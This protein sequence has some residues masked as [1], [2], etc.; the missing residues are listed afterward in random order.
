MKSTL[1]FLFLLCVTL[2]L[3]QPPNDECGGAIPLPLGTPSACPNSTPVTNTFNVT[4]VNATPTTPYPTFSNCSIGNQTSAPADEVWFSFVPN[5]NIMSITV[6]AGLSSPNIVIFTGNN[7]SF[8][9]AVECARG[10]APLTLTLPVVPNQQ[11]YMLISGG[12]IGDQAN[13]TLTMTSSRDCNPCLQSANF[14]A[15]PPPLNGTYNSGQT[16]SFCYT[17]TQWNVTGTIEWLHALEVEFGPG[18]DLNSFS[19]TPP[20]SCDGQGSWNWYDGW[21]SCATGQTFGP[22]FAYDSAAG[23]GC[24]GTPN[25]GNPGNNWGDG[26]NGCANIGGAANPSVTFCW[27]ITV[28]NCPPNT[29]GN[30]LS[31]IVNVLSDGDSGS[32]N[33]VGCNSGNQYNF[34]ASA[35]CCDDGNPFV[36][37]TPTRCPGVSDGTITMEGSTTGKPYNFFLFNSMGQVVFQANGIVGPITASNLPPGTYSVLAVNVESGCQRSEL[38]VINDGDPPQAIADNG[39]PYCPGSPISLFG[40]YSWSGA[41]GPVMYQWSGPGGFSS[42][43]QNPTNA[44]QDGTYNLVVT[45]NG[46]P[47]PPASTTVVFNP[48]AANATASPATVCPGQPATLTAT[49]AVSYVWDTGQSGSSITVNPTQ[50]TTYTVTATN[51]S[52]C[53]TIAF[54]TVDVH[55]VPPL[56]ISGPLTGC[57]GDV[58]VLF[59]VGGAFSQ[60]QWSNG[61][62]GTPMPVDLAAP[63]SDFSVT[64]TTAQGC[65]ATADISILVFN[66]PVGNATAAPATICAGQSST[67][68]ATGGATYIWSTGAGTQNLTVAPAST[69]T[70]RVTVTAVDG[71]RDT[72]SVTVNVV[73][74]IAAPVV[75]CGTATPNSVI[76]TWPAVPNATGYSVNVLSGQTG[77][78]N[79]TTYTVSGLAP[80]TNVTIQVTATSGTICPNTTATF[81]CASQSCPPVMV[82]IVSPGSFCFGAGNSSVTLTGNISGGAGN[83]VR[84]WSGPGITNTTTGIF[85]PDTAGIGSHP[86]ILSYTEGI[87]TYSDTLTIVVNPVP[88]STFSLAPD[89]VCVGTA[90]TITYTGSATAGATYIWNFGGG[91]ATPGTGQGPH[92][93]NWATPGSKTITLTVTE[94]GCTSTVTSRTVQVDAPLAAP[95]ISC[96]TATTTSVVFNWAAVPG[97]TGYTVNV[98]SGPMGTLSGTSYTVTGLMPQQQVQIQVVAQGNTVCGTSSA[99]FT[100]AAAACPVINVNI[101]AVA[102]ICLTANAPV[103]T[104]TA[105]VTGGAGGGTGQW[106]GPGITNASTGAF[107]PNIAG[108]GQH[109]IT[110]TYM[111]GPCS[112]SATRVINVFAT[113]T[114]SFSAAPSPVCIGQTSTLTFSGNAGG[115]AAFAWNFDGGTATPGTGQGPH[116]VTWATAGSKTI[117]L[118]VTENGC[119]ST[120]VN[121]TVVVEAPL[122]APVINCATSTSQIVFSWADVPGATGY[123]VTVLAG[124]MGVQSGNTYTVSGLMPGD[125]SEISVTALSNG[126]CGPNSATLSC[127]AQACPTV[128][129][130]IDPVAP[131]CLSA[132]APTVTLTAAITGGAGGGT[133]VWSGPGV[134]AG[135]NVFNPNVAGVGTHSIS[136]SYTEGTCTFNSSISIVVHAIPTSAF[137]VNSN[138]CLTASATVNYTGTGTA[139]AT[140][141]WDFGGGTAT[142]GTGPGPHTVN[143]ATPGSKTITL[144]V[145]ENGCTSTLTTQ[146]VQVDAPLADPVI[147]CGTATTTSVVF[148][149]TP[150]PGAVIYTVQVLSG[151]TGTQSGNSY[152]VTGLMPGQQVEIRVTAEGNNVCGTSSA[153]FTCAAAA[154]PVIN[155]NIAAV[156]DICLTANAPVQTL[157]ATVTGGAGGG[158]GQWSGPGI[159]NAST[160]AF[161]PNI[162]GVGQHTITYTYMEGPCSQSA[163]RVINVFATPTASFSAAPSPV[164]IGQTSTLTFSGNAGGTAAFAWNF[165]GGTATPGTGQGPHDVTWATAGSKTIS[166]TVTENGC[167]STPVNQTVVVEAPLAAPVINCATSTSQIVFSWADVPGA[168]GYTV[169]VLAGPMG[170]QSGNTY[171]VSGLMPGDASEISVTAL[172]SG[173]CGPSSATL[174]C[175]AQACPTVNI[176][177]APVAPICLTSVTTPITLS[178]TVTGGGGAGT[179]TWA[180]PGITNAATGVFTPATAG[181]GTHTISLTYQEGNCSFNASMT[182][183]VVAQPVAGFTA[184][185]AVCIG[186]AATLSFSGTAPVV[187]DYT[188]NF[189]GGTATPGTG[190]GPHD[191]TWATAGSKTV[192]LTVGINNCLSAPFQQTIQVDAPLAAPQITCSGTTT[193]ITFSWAVVPGATGYQAVSTSGP[194]GVLSGTTYT[195]SGLSPNTSV[196][197]Q[198]TALSNGPCGNSSAEAT[199]IAQNCPTLTLSLTGT[200]AIC[201]GDPAQVTLNFAGASA[202]PFTVRYSINGGT[203]QTGVFTNGQSIPVPAIAT[204]TITAIS[205]TDNSLPDCVYPSSAT[206]TITVNQPVSAGTPTAAARLCAGVGTTLILSDLLENE[207]P[208]G[209]WSETS[210]L[211]SSGGAFNAA[212]G[213]FT[214]S[215]QAARTY[216]FRYSVQGAAPCPA[217]QST[218]TVILEPSPQAD[219][220][221]DQTLTCN[222]GMVSIGGSGTPVGQDIT[223]LWSSATPG[224]TIAEPTARI[225]E[226]AQPGTYVLT[227]RNDIGCTATDEVVVGADFAAPTAEVEVSPISC[228]QAGDGALNITRVNGGQAPYLYSLD[229]GAFGAQQF[230]TG[231]G[232]GRH[233]LVV[234]DHNG[235]FSELSFVLDNPQQLIVNIRTNL[236][237][238]E[239]LIQRGD[240]VQLEVAV[241]G[242]AAIDSIFWKPDSISQNATLIRVQP[243]IATTYSVTVVDA[244]GCRADDQITIYVEH[245]RRVFIPNAFSPNDDG[246]NDVFS[247]FTDNSQVA[248]VRSFFV[249]NR[250]GEAMFELYNFLPNNPSLGWN[251]KHRGK[252]M[253]SG[254][255][256]YVAEIEFTDGEVIIYKGDVVLTQ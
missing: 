186:A 192:S 116:D 165:D 113:P 225:I 191:V 140:Y 159:T 39:G 93:V 92:T 67:L 169:T 248:N 181:P 197:V 204:T 240:S 85:H 224:V 63:Q 33:Q 2:A 135:S 40:N 154:C 6:G 176:A 216:T 195:V 49:G 14:V 217:Q 203:P 68:S 58:T 175:V 152:T 227:V 242:G 106:S 96:G 52:G 207:T 239:N 43:Q 218:V 104:L 161:N 177:I 76:F 137:N 26:N 130:A 28:G 244:N 155:V 250:W 173:P 133:L 201:A 221:T 47:A 105:T 122:A 211:P 1:T 234:R 84:T 44:T 30:S 156:A 5:S 88:T 249:F 17:I 123:T 171:T 128:N 132:N 229:G 38:V 189:D 36:T 143:W 151:P 168:T 37:D 71:C 164:C 223:Y 160:G 163:T 29:T 94:N 162:A 232:P 226:V 153:T 209:T 219:A 206:W 134:A 121:Q 222:M 199:C 251:G 193:S 95:V 215:G 241:S 157:T 66:N 179:R 13:F 97:A 167:A 55:P 253:N 32:W 115:T 99:T 57:D 31:V 70:Y 212:S 89:T 237:G 119:A 247:I 118:T 214:A 255:Y 146:T 7:C 148:N 51:A 182:I 73:Q 136:L 139:G 100:C 233:T 8:L 158:T 102:D 109:T 21:V 138:I 174:S 131:I 50:T 54:V 87:C 120:P 126:P 198:V 112:Q 46:C 196:T 194:Q 78:L 117:S 80:G 145:T 252:A 20:P 103:Q 74:P 60:Y 230:F 75:S 77:T 16:V 144:T 25:D 231:L 34:L 114:A 256:V 150:V 41:P 238:V 12:A 129:I 27:S 90:A 82:D 142:P 9:T 205:I 185:A 65:T 125:A 149:W 190:Q 107:N 10:P 86:I 4:N 236:S 83:G 23:L 243:R 220:G 15:F 111:E 19:P 61:A 45:V 184:P 228:F 202:G 22:G 210:A 200:Q 187:S 3:A 254:V 208:G 180:G 81:S 235:C 213:T 178:A 72:A 42:N 172:S 91:T 124:P 59:P 108:V 11:Y 183:T 188:W 166:L 101:A 245:D 62:S 69:T 246:V 98:L 127:V 79:G 64:A 18:W 170:V 35:V 56:S 24:G 110:Y 147:S 141:D 48:A 53:T